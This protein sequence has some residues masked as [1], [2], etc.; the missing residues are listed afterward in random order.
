MARGI[1]TCAIKVAFPHRE[2][3]LDGYQ[4]YVTGYFAAIHPKYWKVLELDKSIWKLFSSIWDTELIDF[5][6][7]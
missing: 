3:E 2:W 6:K 5:H 7:F 1:T 4:D